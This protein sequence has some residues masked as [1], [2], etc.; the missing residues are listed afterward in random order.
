MKRMV[1]WIKNNKTE[2]LVLIFILLVGAFLRLY[3]ISEYMTFLADEGRDV[4]LV[5]KLVTEGD[6]IFVGPGTSIGT[7]Y[8]GPL[9]YY[10]M[11]PALF[12]SRLSPVGPSIMVA[13]LGVATI[14]LVWKVA[15]E[16][17][18]QIPAALSAILYAT[19]SVVIIF[20]RSSWNPNIMP[21]FA[22]LSLYSI[23]KVYETQKYWWL[24]VL[25]ISFAAVLQ[26]HYLG[27]ILIPVI[28]AFW[29]MT[30]KLIKNQKTE[31]SKFIKFSIAGFIGFILL[32]VP[33]ILFDFKHDFRNFHAMINFASGSKENYSPTLE[34]TISKTLPMFKLVTTRLF[35]P[36]F[37][38]VGLALSILLLLGLLITFLK[39][40]SPQILL[41]IL[42]LVFGVI[43]LALLR[44]D[45]YDHYFGFLFPMPFLL[46]AG[47]MQ[48]LN[49]KI[50]IGVGAILLLF[51]MF[52]LPILGA[53]NM[54]YP[55]SVLI[56]QKILE[57]AKGE[58]F[59][60]AAIAE[61]NNR[62]TYL[63]NL[64]LWGAPV[65]D[66]D[67]QNFD[68]TLVDQLFVICEKV[69]SECDPTHDPSSWITS[70]GWSRIENS[71]QVWGYTI[72]KLVHSEEWQQKQN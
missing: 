35:V 6:L 61:T 26:S 44:Q 3:K 52:S 51:N 69:P 40:N 70:F 13:L 45:V 55:R 39:K 10:M 64:T 38:V 23:W 24:V 25:G 31:M 30:I 59:H 28:F 9:Y 68:N 22:L 18:G 29:L 47:I 37:P 54:Q 46:L 4:L 43:G 1:D 42:W 21:F 60:L 11:A 72:Y 2:S 62:D 7:M 14:F 19:S 8:L 57:E 66:I 67:P 56:A 27:L 50:V 65:V 58:K 12:L 71:W 20:S 17:F 49:K 63:Y 48:N 15:R 16:W 5:R 53:P 32:M 36:K 33:L 41:I 34:N